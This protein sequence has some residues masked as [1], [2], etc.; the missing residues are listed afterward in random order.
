M[1]AL[2]EAD[3][4]AAIAKGSSVEHLLHFHS[5]KKVGDASLAG[6]TYGDFLIAKE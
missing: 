5:L 2:G 1:I 4:K 6:M 3:A